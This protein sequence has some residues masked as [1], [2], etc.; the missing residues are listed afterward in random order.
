MPLSKITAIAAAVAFAAIS[1]TAIA[2][3]LPT[4][5]VDPAI[6]NMT[7][8]E[9]VKARQDAMKED[10]GILRT[11]GALVGDDAVAAATELLQNFTNF[12]ALFREGSVTPDSHALPII[13]EQRDQFDGIFKKAQTGAT[14][15]LQA[16]IDGDD[17]AYADAVKGLTQVCG[18]C[19]QTYRGR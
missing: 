17:A 11:A 16:A 18:E 9:L 3:A 6:A 12:P 10:G 19:H 4:I 8:D 15:M 5:V 13:W 2:Q 1:A 7:N 14:T